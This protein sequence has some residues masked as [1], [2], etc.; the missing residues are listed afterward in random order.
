MKARASP[1]SGRDRLE[2]RVVKAAEAALAERKYVTPI[3]VLV[4]L[5]WL[6]PR[7]VDEWRQGRVDYLERVTQATFASYRGR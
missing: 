7:R 1:G 3:D 4:G 2:R 5:G 6:Q